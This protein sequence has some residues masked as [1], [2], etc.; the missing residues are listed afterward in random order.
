[1]MYL[2]HAQQT[3]CSYNLADW[4]INDQ[5]ASSFHRVNILCAMDVYCTERVSSKCMLAG[6]W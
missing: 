3:I 2:K 6:G 4:F 1:M 5:S